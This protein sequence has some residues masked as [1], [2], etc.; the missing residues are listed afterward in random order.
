MTPGSLNKLAHFGGFS[1]IYMPFWTF[2]ADTRSDWQAEVAHT[3]TKR[4]RSGGKWRT[5]TVTEWKWES[6]HAEL[7]ID[8]LLIA[9]STH[10]SALLW[11]RI[12]GYDLNGLVPYE[13]DYLAG[14]Q[15]QAYE[16]SLEA[17]WEAGRAKIREMNRM[18]CRG[19]ASTPRI[20]HFSMSLD[21]DNESWRYILLPVYVAAYRFDNRTFQ[22]LMNGQTG[23][24]AG[25]RPAS[26]LKVGLASAAAVAPGLILCIIGAFTILFG[27][28]GMLIGTIGLVLLIIGVGLAI[29]WIQE[30]TRMDDA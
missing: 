10:L 3:K 29:R 5:R 28:I 16:T 23:A 27:A 19:Q 11:E 1:A 7:N 2:D 25:Q 18:A 12:N 30:A 20:R 13:P 22:V 17:A 9:G 14:L 21:F 15:A 24:I 8:D 4:Y 26:W 6:G